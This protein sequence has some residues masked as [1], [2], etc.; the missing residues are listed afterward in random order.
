MATKL[1]DVGEAQGRADEKKRQEGGERPLPP[2]IAH[3][4]AYVL[5]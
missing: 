1:F 4:Q 2:D 3:R 5:D